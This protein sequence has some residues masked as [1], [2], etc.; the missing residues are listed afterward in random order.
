MTGWMEADADSASTDSN[1]KR[2]RG[3]VATGRH[4]P[5]AS[6]ERAGAKAPRGSA[7]GSTSA[8]RLPPVRAPASRGSARGAAG[9]VQ[10]GGRSIGA[11]GA[12]PPGPGKRRAGDAYIFLSV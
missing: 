2:G 11:L 9:A 12:N 7:R 4:S 5:E 3:N 6:S 1:G 8:R 10:S